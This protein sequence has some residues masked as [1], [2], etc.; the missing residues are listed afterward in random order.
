[1]G[2]SRPARKV[3]ASGLAIWAAAVLGSGC[4]R[5]DA[6][7]SE[8]FTKVPQY[9]MAPSSTPPP[10]PPLPAKPFP[11]KCPAEGV[12]QGCLDSTSG[13]IM[14]PDSQ[15]ALVAERV[16]GAVKQISVSA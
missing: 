13:L 1:M 14:G 12:M 15:S 10:P 7:Q 5:F 9:E 3:L 8:P 4:A 6:A 11:K 16:T 2:L